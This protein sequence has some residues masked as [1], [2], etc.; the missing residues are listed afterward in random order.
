MMYVGGLLASFLFTPS[1]PQTSRREVKRFE[2]KAE[3]DVIIYNIHRE[4]A[5]KE[6]VSKSNVEDDIGG[7]LI[8]A[9]AALSTTAASVVFTKSGPHS[10]LIWCAALGYEYE[11]SDLRFEVAAW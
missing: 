1:I 8:E 2:E 4:I 10:E 9:G 5:A 3:Y 11:I 6:K 7:L